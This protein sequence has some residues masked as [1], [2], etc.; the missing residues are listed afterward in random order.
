M[1]HK[2]TAGKKVFS[3][4]N[5]FILLLVIIVTAYPLYYVICASLSNPWMIMANSKMLLF[6]YEF[7]FKSY[8]AVFKY[9]MLSTG[10]INTI[11]IVVAGVSVNLLLTSL[12]AYILSRKNVI[13]NSLFMKIIVFTMFFNGGLIP[14]FFTIKQLGL[15]NSMLV[16]ILPSAINTFNL[17]IMKTSFEALPNSIEESAELDGAGH[18]TVLFRIMLPMMMPVVAVMILFYA[19]ERWNSWF[20]AIMFITDRNKYPLQVVLREI[21]LQNDTSQLT[22]SVTDGDRAAVGETIKY[23]IIVVSTLP[24]LLIYPFLQKFFIKGVLVGAVKE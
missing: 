16:L 15:E 20:H 5:N 11:I 21:L 10:Y 14:F 17:I 12:G 22:T 3:T 13:L 4:V 9:P 23:S 19:V 1:T 18:L 6:P 2:E 7:S 24:I 8:E